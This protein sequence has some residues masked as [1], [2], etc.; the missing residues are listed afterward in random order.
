MSGDNADERE[1]RLLAAR[2]DLLLLKSAS[3]NPDAPDF[4]LYAL[5]DQ[6]TNIAVNTPLHGGWLCSWT[7]ERVR[8]YLKLDDWMQ[9]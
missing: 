1:L 7:L 9:S 5:I 4:G 3:R 8:R 6:R 2:K